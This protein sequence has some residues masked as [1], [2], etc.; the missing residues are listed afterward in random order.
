VLY[1]MLTGQLPFPGDTISDTIAAIL[2]REPKWGALPT[3]TPLKVH[4]L[5]RRC[6]QKDPSRRLRD[7]GDARIELEDAQ[8]APTGGT[9]AALPARAVC[10]AANNVFA[11]A[12]AAAVATGATGVH[13]QA[14]ALHPEGEPAFGELRRQVPRI[15]HD[16]DGVFAVG[17]VAAAG[18]AA[19][20]DFPSSDSR[21]HTYSEMIAE[22]EKA[23]ADHPGIGCGKETSTCLGFTKRR[24]W[25]RSSPRGATGSTS[26]PSWGASR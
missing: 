7:I 4:D 18:T 3:R 11:D 6:L 25:R 20:A 15:R 23:A 17:V 16:V 1:E 10:G 5:L 19:A 14:E 2:D 22:L 13:R 21:Y 12:E 24:S 8:T 26:R 9:A